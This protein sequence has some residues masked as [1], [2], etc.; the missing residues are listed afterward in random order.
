MFVLGNI[1]FAV[2]RVLDT[3]LTLYFWVVIISAL[4]TWVRPDPYN[5]VVRTLNALTE[6]VLY[7]S[8]DMV[9]LHLDPS[10]LHSSPIVVLVAIELGAVHRGPFPVPVCGHAAVNREKRKEGLAVRKGRK[11]L[12]GS[13]PGI[14]IPFPCFLGYALRE[15]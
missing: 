3:L 7:G 10:G 12:S 5:P 6:P 1:L 8:A 4:L 13:Q 15:R 9:S 14:A 11:R 2:A